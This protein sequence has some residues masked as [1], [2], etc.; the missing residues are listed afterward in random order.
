MIV[1][2][3]PSAVHCRQLTHPWCPSNSNSRPNLFIRLSVNWECCLKNF[4]ASVLFSLYCNSF[5]KSR[6]FLHFLRLPSIYKS[7]DLESWY[8]SKMFLLCTHFELAFVVYRGIPKDGNYKKFRLWWIQTN[9]V[10]SLK[11]SKSI[12]FCSR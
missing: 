3:R 1:D 7:H 11:T 8:M 12:C 9:R 2:Y 4:E 6:L 10:N 5:R